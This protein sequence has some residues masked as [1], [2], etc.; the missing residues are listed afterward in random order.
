MSIEAD[1]DPV[2]ATN[3]LAELH[4]FS[5]D[6][7]YDPAR[8]RIVYRTAEAAMSAY[9]TLQ[10]EEMERHKWI[11]SQRA[12]HDLGEASLTEWVREYSAQFARYWRRTHVYIP[13]GREMKPDSGASPGQT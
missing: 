13:L 6:C 7:W 8:K 12:N 1:F 9:M 11:E 3:L 4:R 2:T 5:S 10:R